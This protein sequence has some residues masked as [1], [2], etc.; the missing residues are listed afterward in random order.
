MNWLQR[1]RLLVYRWL[2]T[3][4]EDDPFKPLEERG[5]QKVYF[6]GKD[7]Q[8]RVALDLVGWWV[9]EE[10]RCWRFR[11]SVYDHD[12]WPDLRDAL[13]GTI[14]RPGKLVIQYTV[15]DGECWWA[16]DTL[17]LHPCTAEQLLDRLTAYPADWRIV[18]Q[19]LGLGTISRWAL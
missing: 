13:F 10:G 5:F 12:S 6:M 18:A 1:L 2:D 4:D 3:S 8:H 19:R 7:G 17:V 11:A 15:F 16:D 14:S 9:A